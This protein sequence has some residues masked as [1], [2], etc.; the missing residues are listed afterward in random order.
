MPLPS[1]SNNR[2]WAHR[3]VSGQTVLWGQHVLLLQLRS[4]VR[5]AF[6]LPEEGEDFIA[7]VGKN[8][9]Q[10]LVAHELALWPRGP[11]LTISERFKNVLAGVELMLVDVSCFPR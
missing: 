8:R 5:D 3:L 9:T 11:E 7:H 6:S 2:L 10:G 4:T 1:L